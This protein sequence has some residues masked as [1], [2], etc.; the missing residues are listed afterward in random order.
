[1]ITIIA[2]SVV[3]ILCLLFMKITVRVLL[4]H[5]K[6]NDQI[7]IQ[8]RTLFGIIR[9]TYNV[10][11][12]K[13]DKK[14]AN[15]VVGQNKSSKNVGEEQTDNKDVEH[16]SVNDVIEG[17][18]NAKELIEHI[19]GFH[20]IIRN[21]FKKVHV[22]KFEWQTQ[23]G[24]RDAAMTAILSGLAWGVKGGVIGLVSNNMK[25]DTNPYIEIAPSYQKPS[26][27]TKLKCM[28]YFRIGYAILGG[29]RLLKLWKGGRPHFR[30]GQHGH[31]PLHKNKKMKESI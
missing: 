18:Q 23:L 3:V 28:L 2:S 19:V 7:K 27:H 8:L 16:I 17:I 6:D 26:S 12:I 25:L 30:H 22:T 9:Y 14:D 31:P 29:I 11:F 24:A 15:L 10:P 20:Q 5:E 21:F 4:L 1:M 13:V